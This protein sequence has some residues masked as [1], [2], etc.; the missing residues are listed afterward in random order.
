[1]LK[2]IALAVFVLIAGLLAFAAT[3]PDSFSVQRTTTIQAPPEKIF[4]LIN[5]FRQWPQW[6]PWEQ[7]DP[8]MQRSYSGP[9]S[10]LG[11]V[12]GWS[13]EGK[14]GA[15][16]MEITD[17]VPSGKVTIRL[18]FSKPF[19]AHNTA[20]FTLEPEGTATKVTWR[21]FGPSPLIAKV[22][23]LFFSMDDMVGKDFEAGL[24]KMK[25]VAQ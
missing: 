4:A 10:G 20:E 6:S 2:K 16:R 13:S 5:D 9:A 24:A 14:A 12:Y 1:M 17:A 19:A 15:G 22:M 21:M 11:A 18:D 3:R 25:Q 7:L 23:G 8:S